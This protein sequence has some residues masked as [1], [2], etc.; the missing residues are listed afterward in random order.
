MINHFKKEKNQTSSQT[1]GKALKNHIISSFYDLVQD[2]PSH[3]WHVFPY[4]QNK[5]SKIY[6]CTVSLQCEYCCD[7]QAVPFPQSLYRKCHI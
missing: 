4:W 3:A 1:Q 5:M 2:D 6:I 7:L